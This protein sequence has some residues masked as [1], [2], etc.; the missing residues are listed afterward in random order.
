MN[1]NGARVKRTF[2]RAPPPI[3]TTPPSTSSPPSAFGSTDNGGTA[4]LFTAEPNQ[5]K[6]RPPKTRLHNSRGVAVERK[7]LSSPS[8]AKRSGIARAQTSLLCVPVLSPCLGILRAEYH[9]RV[10]RV[11]PPATMFGFYRRALW[12]QGCGLCVNTAEHACCGVWGRRSVSSRQQPWPFYVLEDHTQQKAKGSAA[13]RFGAPP[14]P[15]DHTLSSDVTRR[16]LVH[17]GGHSG[18]RRTA[19]PQAP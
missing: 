12:V 18:S 3:N 4:S 13:L 2:I 8:Q 11:S 7:H 14:P 9:V 17:G 10:Y 19:A 1:T 5:V 15:P 6:Q 16:V